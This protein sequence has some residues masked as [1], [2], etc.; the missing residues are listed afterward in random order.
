MI[1]WNAYVSGFHSRLPGITERLLRRAR[2]GTM[3][4]YD[5]LVRAVA[6]DASRVLDVA[7]GNGAVATTL[8][9]DRASRAGAADNGGGASLPWVVGLDRSREEIEL[10]A[11]AQTRLGPLVRADAGALPFADE[12]FDV[13][14]CSMGLMVAMPLEKV[15]AECARVLRPGGVLAATVSSPL[16]LR[17][18]DIRLLTRLTRRLRSTPQFPNGAE[19]TGLKGALE[20]AGFR[21]LEDARERFAFW[22]RDEADAD[23]VCSSLYLPLIS[24]HRRS[25]AAHWLAK[26]A[27]KA[28]DGVEVAF[29]IRRVL[30]A[31]N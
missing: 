11:Q 5:W 4:P 15:L 14:T 16:P 2:A 27:D 10:A 30:A 23:L 22:V 25:Q 20:D 12:S 28:E 9:T 18:A 29:P 8:G 13:V 17:P 6:A 1:D 26:H 31:R 24:E 21:I 7:C 19:L 3:N